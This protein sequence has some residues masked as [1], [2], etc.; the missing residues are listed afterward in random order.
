MMKSDDKPSAFV[1]EAS[2]LEDYSDKD[3]GG[4][5]SSS[6]SLTLP[7]EKDKKV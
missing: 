4:S 7:F 3:E 2:L 1:G 6:D 5:V